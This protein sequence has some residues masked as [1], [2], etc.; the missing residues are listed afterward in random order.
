MEPYECGSILVLSLLV[1]MFDFSR[2]EFFI[3]GQ[4]E[5]KKEE[6][7]GGDG[8]P[9]TPEMSYRIRSRCRRLGPVTGHRYFPLRR[10]G[11]IKSISHFVTR[12]CLSSGNSVTKMVY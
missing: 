1:F 7:F 2:L 9:T 8:S 12:C 6:R 11:L 3:V 4:R 5:E 10:T